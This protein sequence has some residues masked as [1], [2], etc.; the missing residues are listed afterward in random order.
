[1]L[2]I[3]KVGIKIALLRKGAGYSQEKLAGILCISPQA[4]SKWENGHSLPDT[5]LL[6]V[7]AQIFGCTIDDIIM[8]AY[9]FDEKIEEDKTTEIDF[10]AQQI[11]DKVVKNL[12]VKMGTKNIKAFS[13]EA[14]IKSFQAKNSCIDGCNLT[15]VKNY[16]DNGNSNTE[17]TVSTRFRDY[18]LLER[19]YEKNDIELYR[20][21]YI[22]QYTNAIA[23][24]Y[25]IDFERK[26]MLIEDIKNV[27][28]QCN[29]FDEDNE[30][31]AIIRSNYSTIIK[32]IA[33]LHSVFWNN[34]D[35]FGKIGLDWWHD[36]KENIIAHISGMEKDFKK[37]RKNEET[38]KIP[39]VWEDCG[40]T[41]TNNITSKELDYFEQGIK[42]LK[43]KY[44]SVI[45]S[46]FGSGKNITI[47]HGDLHPG[48]AFVSKTQDRDVKFA[49]LQAVRMGLCTEDLAMLIA[50]HIEPQKEKAH[51]LLDEYYHYLSESVKDYTYEAFMEDY[52][53][54]IMENMFF[55]IKLINKRIFDFKMRDRAIMA[56]E[57]FV[58]D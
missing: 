23:E 25:S 57:T 29:K 13:D 55:T 32:A 45:E 21:D 17:I 37:Y 19:V 47:I 49:N 41:F 15:R 2:D 33:K 38:G 50:L 5:S 3:K 10:Q 58:L 42:L 43:D 27:Y 56:F 35:A 20:Y 40:Y 30:N 31:G 1:M 48:Q 36:S 12:E 9:S 4:I 6:P 52:K 54:S 14:V 24:I 51:P 8:P 22:R 16:K 44:P 26:A 34:Y 46:R 53:L 11:A 7:L 28:I 18:N 39:K